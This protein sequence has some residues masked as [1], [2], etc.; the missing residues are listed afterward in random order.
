MI[1]WLL[2]HASKLDK[3]NII[4]IP[5]FN[6]LAKISS[7]E[8]LLCFDRFIGLWSRDQYGPL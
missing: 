5:W 8:I 2:S 3:H 7:H 4:F 6:N 1:W